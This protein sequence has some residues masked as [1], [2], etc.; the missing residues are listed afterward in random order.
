MAGGKNLYLV[1]YDVVDDRKRARLA[2]LMQDYGH[3]VQKSVFECLLEERRFLRLV[4]EAEKRIDFNEDSI[5]YYLLCGR[6]RHAVRISGF[7]VPTG[8]EEVMVV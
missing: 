5:R 4:I 2:K 1:T 7:G 8:E 3:R 6:C